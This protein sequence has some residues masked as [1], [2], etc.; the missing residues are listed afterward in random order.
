MTFLLL[1][2]ATVGMADDYDYLMLRFSDGT[3]Q[4]LPAAGLVLK[5][6]NGSL[7][8]SSSAMTTVTVSLS[9][10]AAMYL[11]DEATASN[12]TGISEVSTDGTDIQISGRQLMVSAASGSQVIV[13]D[14]AGKVVARKTMSGNGSEAIGSTL[15][16]GVYVIKVNNVSKKIKVL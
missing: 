8:A 16:P 1:M 5:F 12:L 9:E 6:E 4:A 3:E 15:A 2:A 14:V 11:T 13:A 7:V 10:M